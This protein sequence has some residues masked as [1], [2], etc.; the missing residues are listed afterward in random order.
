MAHPGPRKPPPERRC[1]EIRLYLSGDPKGRCWNWTLAGR[2]VCRIHSG[3]GQIGAPPDESRCTGT[4]KNRDRA[5]ERCG[6]WALKGQ[7]VCK[8]HG[9]ATPQARKAAAKRIAEAKL[10][11]EANEVLTSLGGEPVSNPLTVLGE[12]A[13]ELV[14]VKNHFRGLVERL[15][16]VRYQGGS[17]EQI[18]GEL[19]AYQAALRDTMNAVGLMA[20]LNIDERLAIITEKQAAKVIA[21]IDAALIS[22]GV[23]GEAAVSA[24]KVAARKLRAVA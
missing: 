4:T 22:A 17:G 24:K 3:E 16:S 10:N 9:G 19:T 8:A 11:E 14:A 18:R 15:E 5:G 12:L 21:A 20:K 2:D 7:K 13:G 6:E 23:V 1:V